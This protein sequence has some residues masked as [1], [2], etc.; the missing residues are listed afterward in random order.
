MGF[1][2]R[3]ELDK[4][5]R[6]LL[7]TDDCTGLYKAGMLDPLL[8]IEILRSQRYGYHFSVVF[9]DLDHFKVVNDTYGHLVGSKLLAQIGRMI[10]AGC[11][12]IDF[13]FR[14]GG[15]E[16]VVVLPQATKELST[17]MAKRLVSLV[18]EVRLSTEEGHDVGVTASAGTATF[19]TDAQSKDQLLRLAD[20]AM[21]RVKGTTRDNAVSAETDPKH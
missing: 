7:T 8:E 5:M 4:R 3:R 17:R 18:R 19:P 16:F 11:R 12:K 6:F 13:A 15:D 1:I 21:Y 10:E 14:F 20:E 9:L 2:G